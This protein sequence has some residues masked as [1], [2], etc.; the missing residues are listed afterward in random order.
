[1]Q[2]NTHIRSLSIL[3]VSS[4]VTL[5]I[6]LSFADS[7]TLIGIFGTPYTLGSFSPTGNA[8][9]IIVS[10]DYPYTVD[11]D[12]SD[13]TGSGLV[14][15]GRYMFL[16]TAGWIEFTHDKS[17]LP[18]TDI[19]VKFSSIPSDT[20][21]NEWKLAE[22]LYGWSDSAGW[23]DFNDTNVSSGLIYR[24]GG[25]SSFTGYA[26]SENLGWL[27]FSKAVVDFLNKVKVIGSIGGNKTFDVVYNVGE[28]FN[29]VSVTSLINTVRRNIG[30]MTRSVGNDKINTTTSTANKL[31]DVTVLYKISGQTLD[32]ADDLFDESNPDPLRTYI[33]IGSDLIIDGDV[34]KN[35]NVKTSRAIIVLKNEA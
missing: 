2:K 23:I 13:P 12:P 35:P 19:G 20:T 8:G 7:Q 26:W 1:M 34:L 9:K 4:M 10:K 16:E 6:S 21:I 3:L 24:G 30:L 17:A 14:L 33:I 31:N 11:T 29:S 18:G 25:L 27:D 28:K 22:P 15:T 5:G 32:N